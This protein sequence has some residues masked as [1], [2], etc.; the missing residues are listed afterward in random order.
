[1]YTYKRSIMD[2]NVYEI[3]CSTYGFL[4]WLEFNKE[5]KSI[6]WKANS[7]ER[8]VNVLKLLYVIGE[9]KLI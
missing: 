4:G 5:N 3:S 6:L 7:T 8:E 9:I 1:M 2:E